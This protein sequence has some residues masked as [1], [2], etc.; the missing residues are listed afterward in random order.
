MATY[1]LTATDLGAYD[2]TLAAST[3]DTV[4]WTGTT[5]EWVRVLNEGGVG[6]YVTMD[7]T[8]PTVSGAATIK[9]PGGTFAVIRGPADGADHREV[10]RRRDRAR[11]ASA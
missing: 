8:N 2:K 1:N 11:T 5:V 10:D 3:V 7:G 4:T 6:I 9:V